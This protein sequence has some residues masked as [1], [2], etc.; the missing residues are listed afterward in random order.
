ML[1]RCS[2]IFYKGDN[3]LALHCFPYSTPN[4]NGKGSSLKGKKLGANSFLL[5]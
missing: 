5:E 4:P 1:G 2:V 3:F